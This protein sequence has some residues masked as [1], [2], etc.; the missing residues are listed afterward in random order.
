MTDSH[1][2][3]QVALLELE[4]HLKQQ[5]RKIKAVR[6]SGYNAWRVACAIFAIC[7]PDVEPATTYMARCGHAFTG[8]EDEWREKLR[9]WWEQSVAKGTL[10]QHLHPTTKTG[11]MYHHLAEKFVKEWRLHAWVEKVNLE[12][13]IAPC[14]RVLVNPL[15][16]PGIEPTA[17]P[18]APNSTVRPKSK[19]QWLRRW[20]RRWHVQMGHTG[21]REQI[22]DSE[23]QAKVGTAKG[24]ILNPPSLFRASME[25]HGP[26][27]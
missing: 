14:S 3:R 22:S 17:I 10:Q 13:G 1:A 27:F 7:H 23:A 4:E 24:A 11:T 9:Q 19:L 18:F 16:P 6:Q 8:N 15:G 20:R 21:A 26:T 5:K 25:K 12:K 2:G